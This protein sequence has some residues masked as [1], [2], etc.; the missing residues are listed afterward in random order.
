M[1]NLTP[2]SLLVVGQEIILGVTESAT[3]ASAAPQVPPGTT[4]RD[5][6]AYIYAVVAGDSLLAIAAE[7]DLRLAE[8]L[9]LND[10]LTAESLLTVGQEIVVARRPQPASVGGSTDVRAGV[11]S[12]TP[13]P[14]SPTSLPPTATPA[15]TATLE[16][17]ASR[18]AV[19]AITVAPPPL[20]TIAPASSTGGTAASASNTLATVVVIALVG[21]GLLAFVLARRR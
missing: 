8:L 15:A 12:V 11:A 1:N 4:L 18:D 13:L 5:D 20:A 7:Y 16:P 6:G 10:G 21:G 3:Q 14:A 17:T 9:A 2:D 19:A